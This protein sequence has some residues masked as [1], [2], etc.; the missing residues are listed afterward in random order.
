MIRLLLEFLLPLFAP[1][2]AYAFWL[3]WRRRGAGDGA[4]AADGQS[5][6]AT[7]PGGAPWLWLGAAGI[8]LVAVVAVTLGLTRSLGDA[9]GTYVAPRVI[10]GRI[11]PGH[12]DPPPAR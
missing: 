7:S 2:L 3:A 4:D 9:D 1:T 5:A 8:A 10:D 11:V 6:P 12:V